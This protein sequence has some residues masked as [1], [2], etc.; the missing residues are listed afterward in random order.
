MAKPLDLTGKRF[1]R[2]TVKSLTDPYVLPSGEKK[3]RWLCECDCG[4]EIAVMQTHLTTGNT[5]SCGCLQQA[6]A[7]DLTGRKFE[8]IEVLGPVEL[9]TPESGRRLRWL[10]RCKCGKEFVTTRNELM[11]GRKSCGCLSDHKDLTGQRFG[12]L[13]VVAPAEPYVS[14]SGQPYRRW[15]C[16]CR[17]G[18]KVEVLQTQ[19]TS[20]KTRSCGCS[21]RES[22][23]NKTQDMTGMRF[24]KLEVLGRVDLEHPGPNGLRSGWICRCD[25]GKEIVVIRKDLL[26]GK[27]QSCGCLLRET[28]R[29]KMVEQNTVGHYA[30]TT[31]SAINLYRGPNRNNKSGVKGV[32]WSEREQRW[33]AKITVKHKSIT[34]GRFRTLGEAAK[35]RKEAEKKYFAPLIEEYARTKKE[36]NDEKA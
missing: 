1:G 10:C 2:L 22:I 3:R 24:G 23:L 19:L 16:E 36:E 27:V 9:E 20:G 18:N 33:I 13:T 5:K 32:Y 28:A 35:A 15:L 17:C 14:P 11:N 34:I 4:N 29:K 25:C 12:L 8:E 21:R 30:G 6:K 7:E 31:I 26:S